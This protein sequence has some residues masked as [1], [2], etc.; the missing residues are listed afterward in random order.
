MLHYLLTPAV[1]LWAYRSRPGSYRRVRN[2]P[3]VASAPRG[4]GSLTNELAAMP[5]LHVG[6]AVWSA[7]VV[8]SLTARR[9]VRVEALAYPLV[10]VAL[11]VATANHY[12]LDALAGTLVV[13]AGIAVSARPDRAWTV[14]RGE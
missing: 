9:L 12:V 11:V 6:R 7:W 4:L 8:L 2:A 14:G 13:A 1:L 3:V 10:T 5:W